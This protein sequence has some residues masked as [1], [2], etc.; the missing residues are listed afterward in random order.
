[1]E[2]EARLLILTIF[3][4]TT[5]SGFCRGYPGTYYRGYGVQRYHGAGWYRYGAGYRWYCVGHPWW[6]LLPVPIPCGY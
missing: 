6:L 5:V 4:L 2:Y 1:M 3:V